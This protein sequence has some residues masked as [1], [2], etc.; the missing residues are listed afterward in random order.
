MVTRT[1][2][3]QSDSRDACKVWAMI[4]QAHIAPDTPMGAALVDG[5]A[6]FRV[7][8]PRAL[9]VYL[10]GTFGGIPKA[11]RIDDLLMARGANGYWMGFVAGARDGDTYQFDVV[12]KGS[13]G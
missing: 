13:N 11:G 3:E 5:G 6:N 7:W 8:A 12:G 1:R 9:E 2:P 4:S 10:H